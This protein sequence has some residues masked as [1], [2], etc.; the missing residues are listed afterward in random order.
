MRQQNHIQIRQDSD[1]AVQLIHNATSTHRYAYARSADTRAANDLGQ[2]YLTLHQSEHTFIFVLCDGVSQSFYGDLAARILGDALV[3]WLLTELPGGLDTQKIG[4][5][6]DSYLQRLTAQATELVNQQ[7]LPEN[8]PQML[9]EVLEQKRASGSE[10]TFVCGRIDL[11][12]QDWPQGRVILAW[13]GDSR[14]R[15]W[16]PY[17]ERTG[18]LGDRFKTEQRWSS[19]RGLVNGNANLSISPL[20]HEGQYIV[21]RLLA[22]SDGLHAL[23]TQ[24]EPLSNAALQELIEQTGEDATSDDISILEVWLGPLPAQLTEAWS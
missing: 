18:E 2:D 8:I 19:R 1:C 5:V 7:P 14:L 4:E 10:S 22:Y 9:Q 20:Q 15:I 21:Q 13:M 3:S 23:D 11:P 24:A 16:G 6:L 17:G 12:S